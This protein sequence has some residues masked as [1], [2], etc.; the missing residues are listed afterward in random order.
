MR[1]KYADVYGCS[2][3]PNSYTERKREERG[4]DRHDEE[5]LHPDARA[6]GACLKTRVLQ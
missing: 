5:R 6:I 3:H 1:S 4:R 2:S